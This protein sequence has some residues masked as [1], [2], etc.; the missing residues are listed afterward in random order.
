M[1]AP[2]PE[3]FVSVIVPAWNAEETLLET[4]E[5]AAAQTHRNLEILIV[6][7]GSTDRT[8][9]IAAGFCASEPRALLLRQDH[10]GL[11]AARNRAIDEA[12][13][14]Y[15]APLDADDLWHAQK[16]ERQL[17][18]FAESPASVGFVYCWYQ[19]I[20]GEGRV[21]ERPW[22]PVMEGSVFHEHLKCNVGT[23][24]SPLIRRSA[25]GDLRYSSELRN[26]G[27]EDW[28]LQ[29]HIAAGH[30]IACTRAFLLGYRQRPGAMSQQKERM[31]RAHI[32][33]YE[34]IRRDFPG[35]ETR[36]VERELARWHARHALIRRGNGRWAEIARA[37]A[38]APLV[39]GKEMLTSYAS[40][41]ASARHGAKA[42]NTSDSILFSSPS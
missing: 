18:T 12:K 30:E 39:V 38:K 8:G 42:A 15:I 32:R 27:C 17:Q 1:P 40:A 19:M 11:A 25:L 41:S 10:R 28:L 6:D 2:G 33:M 36:T 3:T 34:I 35:R 9:D 16:I 20:D 37:F 7:D 5:S 23:G 31:A 21:T 4:L 13:G 29:L 26:D 24:S 22:A 14:D